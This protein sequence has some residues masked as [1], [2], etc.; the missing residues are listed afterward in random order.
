MNIL[1]MDKYYFIKGGAERYFFELK[2]I[3]EAKGHKV[4]LTCYNKE[5][6]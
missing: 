3:L 5:T 1:M 4:I 2:G 6:S